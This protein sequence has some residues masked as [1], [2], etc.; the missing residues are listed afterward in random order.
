MKQLMML[1]LLVASPVVFSDPV[2]TFFQEITG[3]VNMSVAYAQYAAFANNTPDS[4]KAAYMI[5]IQQIADKNQSPRIKEIVKHLGDLAWSAR[6][7]SIQADAM[8]LYQT[9]FNRIGKKI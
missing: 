8:D 6:G 4:D 7:R 2:P 5:L 3:C 1:L 9:C